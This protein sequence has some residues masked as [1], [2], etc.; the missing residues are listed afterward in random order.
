MLRYFIPQVKEDVT[1]KDNLNIS[2]SWWRTRNLFHQTWL[3]ITLGLLLHILPLCSASG[4]SSGILSLNIFIIRID[5]QI[6]HD[7]NADFTKGR[8]QTES[9]VHLLQT[10]SKMRLAEPRFCKYLWI[11]VHFFADFVYRFCLQILNFL[12]TIITCSLNFKRN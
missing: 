11:F 12:F 4:R 2:S 3:V 10:I 8:C 1:F 5:Q 6:T 7:Q 9:A